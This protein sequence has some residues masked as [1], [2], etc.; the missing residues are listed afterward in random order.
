M[1]GILLMLTLVSLSAQAAETGY[2]IVHPDGSVEYTDQAVEGA[3]PITLPEIPT[4]SSPP[5]PPARTGGT[6]SR[7]AQPEQKTVSASIAITSPS[8]EQT[9]WFS[10]EGMAVAVQVSPAL[11]QGE[12]VVIRL[13]GSEVAR[14]SGSSFTLKQVYRGSH[15]LS[16]AIVDAQGNVISEAPPITFYMRQHS[17]R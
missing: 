2:R 15:L 17:V 7:P 12:Q 3:E 4:Y 8:K 6:P 13:D 9:L 5:S 14:G 16:A 11:R 10:E 1:K